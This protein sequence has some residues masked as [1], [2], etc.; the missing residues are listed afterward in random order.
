MGTGTGSDSEPEGY[1]WGK[2]RGILVKATVLIG[3]A[4][5]LK[6]LTKSTTRWDHARFV[7]HSLSGEKVHIMVHLSWV[8]FFFFLCF[9]HS[10]IFF[11]SSS[12]W[13]KLPGTLTTTSISGMI[14]FPRSLSLVFISASIFVTLLYLQNGHLPCSR[15]GGW[16]PGFIF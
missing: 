13:S 12:P 4:I 2:A 16:F 5:L 7:S 8:L 6:K 1:G 3:G 9:P 15:A 10:I 14:H 11:F